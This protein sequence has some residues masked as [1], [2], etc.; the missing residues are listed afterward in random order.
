LLLLPALGLFFAGL[1]E[2]A[3]GLIFRTIRVKNEERRA[4]VNTSAQEGMREVSITN[5]TAASSAAGPSAARVDFV[6]M[7]GPILIIIVV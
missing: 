2:A 7:G 1:L 5:E 6:F 3:L 4:V